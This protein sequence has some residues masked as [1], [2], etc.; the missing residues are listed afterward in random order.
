M[1]DFLDDDIMLALSIRIKLNECP[2][3]HALLYDGLP[4]EKTCR[5]YP[6][7]ELAQAMWPNPW[8]GHAERKQSTI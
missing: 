7:E 6:I 4:H 3:C 5:L 1:S 2:I 8:T